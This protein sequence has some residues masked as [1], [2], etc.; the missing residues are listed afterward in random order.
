MKSKLEM[1]R[2]IRQ[3]RERMRDL[4]ASEVV[5]AEGERMRCDAERARKDGLRL[6][7]IDQAEKRFNVAAKITD[8]EKIGLEMCDADR[9]LSDA[10]QELSKAAEVS[11]E[12]SAHLRERERDLRLSEK[13]V[14][15]TRKE[16]TKAE[17]KEEQAMVDDITASRWS[18]ES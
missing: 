1:L 4:A 6:E 8:I 7:I 13:L 12:A 16:I 18:Q 17:A 14:D 10:E 15:R 5:A 2:R 11:Q 9:Y 3:A